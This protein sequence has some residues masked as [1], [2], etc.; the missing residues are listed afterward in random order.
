MNRTILFLLLGLGAGLTAHFSYLRLHAVPPTDSLEGQLAWMRSELELS[1]VQFAQIK[2]LHEASSPRLHAM[3]VQVSQ[4]QAEL[5]AFEQTRR[6][7]DRVDFLEFARFVEARRQL[8]A[9]CRDSTQ[10]L[11]MASAEIMNPRQRERYIQL[12][13]AAGPLAALM[14]N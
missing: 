2:Q 3:T 13:T 8:N 12:V 5:T 11:V 10:Q 7:S 1:D 14:L 6:N 4:L 9:A